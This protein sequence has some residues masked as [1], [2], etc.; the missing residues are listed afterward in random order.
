MLARSEGQLAFWLKAQEQ[1]NG[2]LPRRHDAK[3]GGDFFSSILELNTIESDVLCETLPRT[4]AQSSTRSWIS[5]T[6]QG[7]IGSEL[8]RQDHRVHS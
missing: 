6:P 4:P 3:A 5:T 8:R 7:D 1:K 2:R